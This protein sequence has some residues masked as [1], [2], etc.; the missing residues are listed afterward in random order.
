MRRLLLL[1]AISVI[2]ISGCGRWRTVSEYASDY[3]NSAY[4][5]YFNADYP[6]VLAD[7]ETSLTYEAT[8]DAL[9][10]K[11][12]VEY[13]IKNTG[14]AYRLLDSCEGSFPEDGTANLLRAC[15]LSLDESADGELM[16]TQ[17]QTAHDKEF[18]GLGYESFWAMAEEFDG[19][20]HFRDNFPVQYASLEAMKTAAPDDSLGGDGVTKFQKQAIGPALYICHGDMWM[21]SIA[22]QLEA[23]IARVCIPKPYNYF[24]SEAIKL[25]TS[26]IKNKDKGR[27]VKLQWTWAVWVPSLVTIEGFWTS[28]Q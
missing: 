10:F 16:L 26:F 17:L 2:V 6:Q 19:F 5:A 1:L 15:F 27:G 13:N 25:R 23:L 8:S 3:L 14:E 4:D 18:G 12:Q 9:L 7:I 22:R 20:S 24:V 11:A 28:S 21:I